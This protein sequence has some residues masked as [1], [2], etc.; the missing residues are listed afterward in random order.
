E[1]SATQLLPKNKALAKKLFRNMDD[2][3]VLIIILA[4]V[5]PPFAMFMYEGKNWTKRCTLSLILTC[6]CWAPGVVYTLMNI[7]GKK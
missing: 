6:I 7:L 2:D 3:E 1:I 4:F 5:C